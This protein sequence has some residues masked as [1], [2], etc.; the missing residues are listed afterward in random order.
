MKSSSGRADY[1]VGTVCAVL[2]VIAL[3]FSWTA[4]GMPTGF[5]CP[6]CGSW[7][8]NPAK[9]I[10]WHMQFEPGRE[11]PRLRLAE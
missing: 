11:R 1:A 7:V 5:E 3:I 6:S 8:V 2:G 10:E 9:H 4:G